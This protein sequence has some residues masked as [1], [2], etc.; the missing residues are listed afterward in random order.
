MPVFDVHFVFSCSSFVSESQEAL[1]RSKKNYV[2]D[3]F[4]GR[5]HID[6]FQED[7]TIFVCCFYHLL[8]GMRFDTRERPNYNKRVFFQMRHD[9]SSCK[10]KKN[11]RCYRKSIKSLLKYLRFIC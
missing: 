1:L 9:G 8:D 2:I 7:K 3:T 4:V 6:G 5:S 10:T 11:F